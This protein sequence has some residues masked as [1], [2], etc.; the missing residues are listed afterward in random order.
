MALTRTRPPFAVE[1]VDDGRHL[2]VDGART[3]VVRERGRERDDPLVQFGLMLVARLAHPALDLQRR[4]G[5][6]GGA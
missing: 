2:V 5:G 3:P 6:E 4:A 1:D